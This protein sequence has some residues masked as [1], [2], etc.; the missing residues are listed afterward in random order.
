MQSHDQ[1]TYHPPPKSSAMAALSRKWKRSDAFPWKNNICLS[2][3][4][5][6]CAFYSDQ[7]QYAA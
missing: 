7:L 5:C 6:S 3:K 1:L 4:R 2:L